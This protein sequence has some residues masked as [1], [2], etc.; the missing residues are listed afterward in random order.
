MRGSREG[1]GTVG[2][3]L[4]NKGRPV[5][6]NR[7]SIAA[8]MISF[9]FLTRHPGVCVCETVGISNV[10]SRLPNS[11]HGES[12]GFISSPLP[13]VVAASSDLGWEGVEKK[14]LGLGV[15]LFMNP[16]L[17]IH[18]FPVC[19]EQS[20]ECCVMG[21]S[22]QGRGESQGTADMEG[23]E[24]GILTGEPRI[25]PKVTLWVKCWS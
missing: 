20:M 5:T 9:A 15:C 21:P 4:S 19:T 14:K 16:H 13:W 1:M 22:L 11:G 17:G 7:M 23:K 25:D 3:F 2:S 24:V 8:K 10:E 18:S 12:L 6:C